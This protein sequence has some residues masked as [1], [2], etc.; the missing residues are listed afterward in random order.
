LQALQAN[1]TLFRLTV[2]PL[3]YTIPSIARAS[4][5]GLLTAA[6]YT[7]CAQ[8]LAA[9]PDVYYNILGCLFVPSPTYARLSATATRCSQQF[10]GAAP[11]NTP[12]SLDQC[13]FSS[14][15]IQ[16]VSNVA[17]SVESPSL[18]RKLSPR[19]MAH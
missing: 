19:R 12:N 1:A 8:A 3:S 13:A 16:A 7:V 10:F 11:N 4:A 2:T 6:V 15:A 14:A 18:V 5:D 9:T 17:V